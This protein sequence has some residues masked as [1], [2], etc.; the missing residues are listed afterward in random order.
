MTFAEAI[1]KTETGTALADDDLSTILTLKSN[2]AMGSNITYS[3]TI[4][5]AKKVITIDP[6]N[7]LADGMVYVAI[8]D[9]YYD[10]AGNQGDAA[11]ATFTVDTSVP[12]PTSLSVLPDHRSLSLSWTAPTSGTVTGYEVHYTSASDSG[13]NAVADDATTTGSD[14][15]MAWKVSSSSIAS[16]ATG[17]SITS[18]VNGRSYRVRVRTLRSSDTS[19]WVFGTGTPNSP[20]PGQPSGPGGGG[21]QRQAGPVLDGAGEVGSD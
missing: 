4:D 2:D 11:N 3:A 17:H 9:G 12:P 5:S 1:R 14:A 8:S 15:S 20:T 18:V 10:V 13:S 16:T 19:V 21:R 6:T 7:N